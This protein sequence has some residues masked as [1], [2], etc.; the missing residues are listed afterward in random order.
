VLFPP[1]AFLI[2]KTTMKQ[3]NAFGSD[4]EKK[5]ESE[6]T[7]KIKTPEYKPRGKKPNIIELVDKS[8]ANRLFIEIDNSNLPDEE[9]QFL[10]I[11]ATRHYVFN[12]EKIAD[13]YAHSSKDVQELMER[14]A[15]VIIDFNGLSTGIC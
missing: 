12:Y 1:R 15:L 10:K 8:K 5:L 3:L 11:A 7:S 4:Y 2:K 9:K 6:Y 14:Q 13:Y